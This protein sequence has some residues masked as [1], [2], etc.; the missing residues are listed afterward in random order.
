VDAYND[1]NAYS[2]LKTYRST[3]KL[4]ECTEESGCFKKV[5]QKGETKGYPANSKE[6]SSEIS[7]DL[8]M[9]S[10]TCPGCHI[11]LVEAENTGINNLGEAENEAA[12]LGATVISN[13]YGGLETKETQEKKSWAAYDKD[14]DHAGV[15]ITVAS[16]DYGYGVEF[17]ASSQ[18]VIAAGGTALKKEEKSTRGW[19][20]EVWRNTEFKI[21]EKGAGT[22]SGCALEEE[23]KK[24]SWQQDTGCSKRTDN[25]VAAVAS[26]GTPVSMYDTYEVE[27]A[28][29]WEPGC[30]TSASAPIIA[31]IEAL[32]E[33]PAKELG[34]EVFYGQPNAEF[35]VTK[36]SDGECGGSY[37]CT[38]GEGYNGPA[39]MGAPDGVPKIFP[40][41]EDTTPA[42]ARNSSSGSQWVFYSDSNHEI[43]YWEYTK[44]TGWTNGALGGSV[45]SDS[46]PAVV[47][48]PSTGDQWV[49]YH[50]SNGYLHGW[51]YNGKTWSAMEIPSEHAFASGASP[52]V[53]AEPSSGHQWIYYQ[54]SSGYLHGWE[55][56]GKTWSSIEFSTHA[57]AADTNPTVVREAA[58]GDQWLY[59]QGSNAE[60]DGW[61]Y[62]GK[63]WSWGELGGHA[64][65]ADS[66]PTMVRESSTGEMWVYYQG[67]NAEF[68]GRGYSPGA[69]WDW[70][71]LTGHAFAADTSPTMARNSSTGEIWVYYQGSN[72]ELKGG[73][74]TEKLGWN[75]AEL[76]GHPFA[77]DASPTVV[78]D[79][80][81]GDMWI[82][83]ENSNDEIASWAY[84][85]SSWAYVE[86]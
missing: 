37:L 7:L 50:G 80:S 66:S 22:G 24:P 26:C 56:N 52:V 86:P 84:T 73:V 78:R 43:A 2:D 44:S 53:I 31:G 33:K 3:Y 34:A 51:E 72:S 23:D 20:E 74:Y 65:A 1:P 62:V 39:G 13:S 47:S 45:A 61:E 58:T 19:S 71:E 54:D 55:Y 14:Y 48:E 68:D 40:T 70:A 77:T 9:V 38:A 10:A 60:F 76:A 82:Y 29:W 18:Y 59:Y 30:G 27:K 16:G 36:G 75:F 83:Y 12:T 35:P 6:W 69:G 32:A 15:P 67:S 5:N 57:F 41:A 17:P 64:F 25:D 21:G 79:Q 63:T 49:Y 46:N 85:S 8:D 28:K 81:S 42:V 4:P 11:L